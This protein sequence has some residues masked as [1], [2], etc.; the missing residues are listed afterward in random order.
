[1][2]FKNG[3]EVGRLIG[4]RPEAMYREVFDKVLATA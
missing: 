3:K 2:I 1:V 4:A